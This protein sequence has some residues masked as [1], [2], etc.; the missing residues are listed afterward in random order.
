MAALGLAT[1]LMGFGTWSALRASYTF[2]DSNLEILVYAQGGSDLRETF[3]SLDALVFSAEPQEAGDLLAP[4]RPVEVDYDMWYP[5]QWYVRDAEA[6]GLLRFACFKGE[7]DD[8]WNDGC[9]SLNDAPEETGSK[10]TALL[11][12]SDHANRNGA[13]LDGYEK[14][15]RLNSLLWFPETYRRP[16]EARQDEEWKEEIREDLGFFKDVASSR[17]A[18]RSALG[19]WIFRDLKQDWFTGDY[20]LFGR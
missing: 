6:G 20:Y 12:T 7:D 1:L 15:E 9:N 19:Y 8:G 17:G 2:D 10:P 4:R 11:L 13:E 14:S 3:A 16:A 5:F 18:W